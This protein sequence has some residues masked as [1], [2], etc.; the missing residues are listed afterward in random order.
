MI[1]GTLVYLVLGIVVVEMTVPCWGPE[2]IIAVPLW[3]VVLGV[4]I[5]LGIK[6]ARRPNLADP[7][8]VVTILAAVAVAHA[9]ARKKRDDWRWN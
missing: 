2:K 3:P 9:E 4:S 7:L 5:W 8:L 1:I 6:E